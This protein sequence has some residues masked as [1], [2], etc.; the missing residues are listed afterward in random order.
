MIAGGSMIVGPLGEVLAGPLRGEEGSVAR[1]LVSGPVLTSLTR[2]DRPFVACS[3]L[4]ATLDLDDIVRGK[5]DLDVVGH[6]A[7]ND[8]FSLAV[9][10]YSPAK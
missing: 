4:T 10:G 5:Y 1:A 7:R 3:V 8:I 6:Y 9:K 2:F